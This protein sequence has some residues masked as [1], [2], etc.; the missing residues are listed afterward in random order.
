M[1]QNI[2]L[3]PEMEDAMKK[4][5]LSDA[6]I[7]KVVNPDVKK[8]SLDDLDGFSGGVTS[9]DIPDDFRIAGLTYYDMGSIMQGVVDSFGIDVAIDV[10]I[11]P[12]VGKVAQVGAVIEWSIVEHAVEQLF[13]VVA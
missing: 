11:L 12:H 13:A 5:N 4:A 10:G 8:M 1:A 3:T 9:A 2:R 7:Q 6:D